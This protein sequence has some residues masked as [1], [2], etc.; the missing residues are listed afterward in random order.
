MTTFLTWLISYISPVVGF[1][2]QALNIKQKQ[3]FVSIPRTYGCF[4][5]VFYKGLDKKLRASYWK[6]DNYCNIATVSYLLTGLSDISKVYL[7]IV[8]SESICQAFFQDSVC[9]HQMISK[10]FVKQYFQN[11]IWA[12]KTNK[13]NRESCL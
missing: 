2:K 12:S 4:C 9:Y 8:V 10:V 5:T 7:Q 13:E 6:A 1:S 3:N 11:L